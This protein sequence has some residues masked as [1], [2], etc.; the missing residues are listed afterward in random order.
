[1]GKEQR[2]RELNILHYNVN[3]WDQKSLGISPQL[4][5]FMEIGVNKVHGE[6]VP[7]VNKLYPEL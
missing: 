1:M 6:R 3:L 4:S 2:K 7:K 5:L